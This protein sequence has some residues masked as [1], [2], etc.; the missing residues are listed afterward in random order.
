MWF[1][2]VSHLYKCFK[3]GMFEFINKAFIG[4]NYNGI[5]FP[6][7]FGAPLTPKL[8]DGSYKFMVQKLQAYTQSAS[9]VWCQSTPT[10]RWRKT[11]KLIFFF[12]TLGLELEQWT[13][14]QSF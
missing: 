9:K 11:E 12:V 7:I 3:F 1:G 13:Q 2:Q 10:A 4:K 5:S 6:P 14:V 8:L